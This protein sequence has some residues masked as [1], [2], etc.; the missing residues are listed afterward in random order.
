MN[1][2]EPGYLDEA[3]AIEQLPALMASG[4]LEGMALAIA[5]LV[6][7]VK[8]TGTLTAGLRGVWKNQI[9]PKCHTAP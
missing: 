6:L 9:L 8:G 7:V 1:G 5:R 3:Q 4:E 2:D